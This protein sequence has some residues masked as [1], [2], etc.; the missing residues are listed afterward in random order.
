[1]SGAILGSWPANAL[2]PRSGCSPIWFGGI[3]PGSVLVPGTIQRGLRSSRCCDDGYA[4]ADWQEPGQALGL[5]AFLP[6]EGESEVDA[7]A[8]TEPCLLFGAGAAGHQVFLDLVKARQ[9]F[10][11]YGEHR[12]SQACVRRSML[13]PESSRLPLL[14][15]LEA[16]LEERIDEARQ[17]VWLGEVAGL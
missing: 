13:R 9:H 5:L 15:E 12:A 2:S 1:A 14:R 16:N 10:R 4:P 6:E 3:V 11:V 8:L 17:R 7:P